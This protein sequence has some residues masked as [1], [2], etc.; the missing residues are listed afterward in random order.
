VRFER[1]PASV[2]ELPPRLGA[3]TDAILRAAGYGDEEIK[4]LR[5]AGAVA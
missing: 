4:A 3:Q 1:T 5:A 2:R